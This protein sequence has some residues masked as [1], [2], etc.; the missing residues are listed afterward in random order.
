MSPIAVVSFLAGL[1]VGLG[2]WNFRKLRQTYLMVIR[3]DRDLQEAELQ[4][5]GIQQMLYR[6]TMDASRHMKRE[7]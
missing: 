3:L 7:S 2:I 6:H 4:L 1:G 5:N